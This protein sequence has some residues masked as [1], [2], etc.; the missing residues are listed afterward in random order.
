MSV[1]PSPRLKTKGI[2]WWFSIKRAVAVSGSPHLHDAFIYT[3]ALA[4]PTGEQHEG[5][6]RGG[7]GNR[8]VVVKSGAA[9]V[10]AVDAGWDALHH[11]ASTA[12]LLHR[13]RLIFHELG[14]DGVRSGGREVEDAGAGSRGI[15]RP[16]RRRWNL[17]WV[18]Q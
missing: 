5:V 7:E 14:S 2:I 17:R 12:G 13:Q 10:A 8:R 16:S 11:A 9:C 15:R 1:I 18:W 3:A 6:G 4:A